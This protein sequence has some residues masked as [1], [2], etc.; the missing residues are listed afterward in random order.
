MP[1]L[2]QHQTV[3][4]RVGVNQQVT[5]K[6][7]AE[8]YQNPEEFWNILLARLLVHWKWLSKDPY[9]LL[10]HPLAQRIPSLSAIKTG[11]YNPRQIRHIHRRPHY[12]SAEIRTADRRR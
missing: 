5:V 2:S 7:I 3:A 9:A 11:M 6:K 1:I 4:D 8:V 12:G 10:M